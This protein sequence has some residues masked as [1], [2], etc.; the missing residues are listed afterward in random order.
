MSKNTH[1]LISRCVGRSM[2]PLF[3]PNAIAVVNTHEKSFHKGSLVYI[4]RNNINFIHRVINIDKAKKL[5]KTQGDNSLTS[6]GWIREQ[7]VRGSVLLFRCHSKTISVT[8]WLPKVIGGIISTISRLA[9]RHKITTHIY[10][11]IIRQPITH[12]CFHLFL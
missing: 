8:Q 5:V 9:F 10:R 7:Y 2:L 3:A 6:D 12:T 1:L 11:Y 4:S